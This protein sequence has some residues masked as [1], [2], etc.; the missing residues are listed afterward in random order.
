MMFTGIDMMLGPTYFLLRGMLLG[1]SGTTSKHEPHFCCLAAL[2]SFSN[3]QC[4][5]FRSFALG[6]PG[7]SLERS[8][9]PKPKFDLR[10]FF[11]FLIAAHLAPLGQTGVDAG[12]WARPII[13]TRG[14]QVRESPER[15]RGGFTSEVVHAFVNESFSGCKLY[16]IS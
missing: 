11:G 10:W 6:I 13:G 14:D 8:F 4:A 1:S 15:G 7:T 16:G 3:G 2:S 12:R 9:Q 5:R